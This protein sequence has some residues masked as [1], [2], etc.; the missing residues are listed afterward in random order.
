MVAVSAPDPRVAPLLTAGQVPQVRLRGSVLL[1]QGGAVSVPLVSAQ[2]K[3]SMGY[4]H[5]H[6]LQAVIPDLSKVEARDLEQR[7]AWDALDLN[8]GHSLRVAVE[9]T[10][11]RETVRAPQGVYWITRAPRGA[12]GAW[13]V[14]GKSHEELVRQANLL[15]DIKAEGSALEFL[16]RR[17]QAAV[18]GAQ[19][20]WGDEDITDVRLTATLL[21]ADAG[22]ASNVLK[23]SQQDSA[24][25]AIRSIERA[26]GWRVGC[27]LEGRWQVTLPR[28]V[29]G[30][31]DWVIARGATMTS[32]Q[33]S[34]SLD[35]VCNVAVVVST[36][37]R[38]TGVAVDD[39]PG[40]PTYPGPDVVAAA[41]FAADRGVN[42]QPGF[43]PV[44][45]R[46]VVMDG[47][48]STAQAMQAARGELTGR[49]SSVKA[50]S[51]W[52]PW[53]DVEDR[54]LIR[55]GV[56]TPRL[57]VLTDVTVDLGVSSGGMDLE[58]RE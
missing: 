47:I 20:E 42:A 11:G 4:I 25:A 22:G 38:W 58:V 21:R 29:S 40:S 3:S 6:E 15:A 30:P 53:A 8:G 19:L 9:I 46:R 56:E 48:G 31:P 55:S 49:R 52:Q 2:R 43:W 7:R 32:F 10:A 13:L 36:D 50:G 33:G 37:E 24:W 54:V 23:A 28:A 57:A 12:G 35:E 39:R 16:A 17:I 5:R 18:P 41:P 14:T 45:A 44:F 34:Q 1:R 26:C 51:T 27:D